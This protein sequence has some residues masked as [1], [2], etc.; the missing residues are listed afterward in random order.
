M[1]V[2]FKYE[3][4][5]EFVEVTSDSGCK[6]LSDYYKDS[7][8]K[9]KFLC[10]CGEQF[11]V[12]FDSFKHA[13]KRQ[14]KE[15]GL[16][17]TSKKLSLGYNKVQEFIL[18]NS[19]C[20]LLSQRY[21]NEKEVL[22]FLCECGNVFNTTFSNFKR[23]NKR[24]CDSC[25]R[26]NANQNRRY[27]FQQ[28]KKFIETE[29]NSKLLSDD[30]KSIDSPLFLICG[31][32]NQYTTTFYRFKEDYKR[33]CDPCGFRKGGL[34]KRKTI[35]DIAKEA[36][37]RDCELITKEYKN[38]N[39]KL[40][41]KCSCGNLFK[42]TYSGLTGKVHQKNRCSKCANSES[43]GESKIREFLESNQLIFG[44]QIKLEGCEF[45]RPLKF[46]FVIYNKDKTIKCVIEYDGE[47]HRR[48]VK[49]FGGRKKFVNTQ[50]RDKVKNDFCEKNQIKLVRI[51]DLDFDSIEEILTNVLKQP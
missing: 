23:K 36:K 12:N 14:C 11:E 33:Q 21:T 28:V 49:H 18:T 38:P 47:Q 16:K 48:I 46:D 44:S 5:K 22:L 39:S 37:K 50:I 30:Y 10:K 35:E 25:G 9:M 45:K 4:V 34:K 8:T 43:K 51:S 6:L 3:D 19:S 42:T 20:K 31:C 15:C 27:T 41:F 24:Q 7:K 2:G 32:N 13:H 17:I 1:F 29:S 26:R 40:T